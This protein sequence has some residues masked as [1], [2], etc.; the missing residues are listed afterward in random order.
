[1]KIANKFFKQSIIQTIIMLAEKIRGR[2]SVINLLQYRYDE[3]MKHS[4]IELESIRDS[5]LKAYNK[6]MNIN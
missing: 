4:Y 1:M 6:K 2:E 3:M 5:H